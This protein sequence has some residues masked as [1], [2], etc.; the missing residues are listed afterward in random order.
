MPC[1]LAYACISFHVSYFLNVAVDV[2]FKKK[3]ALSDGADALETIKTQSRSP[4]P[5]VTT[6]QS[7]KTPKQGGN[8]GRSGPHSTLLRV[9]IAGIFWNMLSAHRLDSEKDE[10][11]KETEGE[12]AVQAPIAFPSVG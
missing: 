6:Q 7:P 12:R 10:R 2:R 3:L 11:A 9:L 8:P 5:S 4:P 1:Q